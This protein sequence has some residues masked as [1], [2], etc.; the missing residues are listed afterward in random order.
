[1]Q[2]RADSFDCYYKLNRTFKNILTVQSIYKKFS[3]EA[4]WQF[5]AERVARPNSLR[6]SAFVCG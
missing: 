6:H 4:G 2:T 3:R 5:L 1:M